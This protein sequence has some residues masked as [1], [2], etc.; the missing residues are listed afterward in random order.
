M[1][2]LG[3]ADWGWHLRRPAGDADI[4]RQVIVAFNAV[5]QH[6]AVANPLP[7]DIV[8]KRDVVRSMDYIAALICI[9]DGAFL[10]ECFRNAAPNRN[11]P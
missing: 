3:R 9:V 10:H 7:C 6:E 5:F 2:F 11:L 1:P 4:T 8:R